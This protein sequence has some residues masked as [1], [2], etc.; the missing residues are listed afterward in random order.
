ME[1]KSNKKD[2]YTKRAMCEKRMEEGRCPQCG[3]PMPEAAKGTYKEKLTYCSKFA[4]NWKKRYESKKNE[5][6][7]G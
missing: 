2:A 4:G 5:S 7:E 6:F 3:R 1:L